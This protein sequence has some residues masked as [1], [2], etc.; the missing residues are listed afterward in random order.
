MTEAVLAIIAARWG[1]RA[2]GNVLFLAGMTARHAFPSFSIVIEWET[3]GECGGDRA[4]RCLAELNRQMHEVAPGCAD[5]PELILVP[6][7]SPQAVSDAAAAAAGLDWPGR[8]EVAQPPSALDYYRKKNFGFSRSAG[9]I[10][11]FVDSDLIPEAGWLRAMIEPFADAAKSVVVGRTHFDTGSLY[12]RA[13]ALF[14]I[15]DAR[16]AGD[17]VRPTRRLVSN[18]IAFRRPLFS[19]M[20]F[21]ERD[22]YRGQCSELGARLHR[23]GIILYEATAARASHP[24]PPTARAFA[25]RAFRAGRDAFA[26]RAMEG[27]VGLLECTSEWRRDLASSRRRRIERAPEIGA[28]RLSR[29]AAAVLGAAYYTIKA[30]G[31]LT[32]LLRCSAARQPSLAG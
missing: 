17:L 3:G 25:E 13:M 8:F 27:P 1:W 28:G 6:D 19:A 26:Y 7:H 4:E 10:V 23:L 32:A 2:A 16:C 29:A 9:E 21:P 22:T 11:L 14:W 30:A 15:F 5:A 24:A 18:N 31:F 20:P 12:E